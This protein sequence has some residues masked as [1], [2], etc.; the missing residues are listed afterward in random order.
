MR[1]NNCHFQSN[2]MQCRSD[3]QSLERALSSLP[4]DEKVQAVVR[5]LIQSE[6]CAGASSVLSDPVLAH[7]HHR[8]IADTLI[9]SADNGRTSG[10]LDLSDVFEPRLVRLERI[11]R[12]SKPARTT[13]ADHRPQSRRAPSR[14]VSE[15]QDDAN[16]SVETFEPVATASLRTSVP[17]HRALLAAFTSLTSQYDSLAAAAASNSRA[18]QAADAARVS[19]IRE[20]D[21]ALAVARDTAAAAASAMAAAQRV[22]SAAG[23]VIAAALEEPVAAAACGRAYCVPPG[24]WRPSARLVS[25][26]AAAVDADASAQQ[27]CAAADECIALSM[28][29]CATAAP[30]PPS[31]AGGATVVVPSSVPVPRTL[32]VAVPPP[33]RGLL[34]QI[35]RLAV[36]HVSFDVGDALDDDHRADTGAGTEAQAQPLTLAPC[37]AGGP[38]RDPPPSQTPRPPPLCDPPTSAPELVPVEPPH[39]SGTVPP[40]PLA[41]RCGDAHAPPTTAAADAAVAAAQLLDAERTAAVLARIHALTGAHSPPQSATA[42]AHVDCSAGP[43]ACADAR[44]RAPPRRFVDATERCAESCTCPSPHHAAARLHSR[45]RAVPHTTRAGGPAA[46]PR[47]AVCFVDV[48]PPPRHSSLQSA[49]RRRAEL[50]AY[51]QGGQGGKHPT[52]VLVS[53]RTKGD[54][55]GGDPYRPTALQQR[56]G[57]SRDS[58]YAR[59]GA[60]Q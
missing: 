25:A 23:V 36:T 54:A 31:A 9:S 43:Y 49:R 52:V 4:L 14:P 60:R 53:R 24:P 29:V 17:S 28:A 39:C 22:V 45:Q 38:P 12:Q 42:A 18:T 5:Q 20:R 26:A 6:T 32:R 34:A 48:Q 2:E 35:A 15:P 8:D 59:S 41:A 55:V 10:S 37:A 58:F 13:D 56:R 51:P 50:C 11:V 19:A 21:E 7:S 30:D 3:F 33:V 27:A 46:A 47:R 1:D 40:A 57:V 16:S 44:P